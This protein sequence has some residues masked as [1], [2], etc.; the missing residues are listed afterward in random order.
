M[1]ADREVDML[2]AQA[3][4]PLSKLQAKAR[5]LLQA[6]TVR[7]YRSVFLSNGKLSADGALVLADLTRASG[8]GKVRPGASGEEL[9]F[10]E[11]RRA[12]L[13]HMFAKLDADTLERL[14][15]RIRE[16]DDDE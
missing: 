9:N 4:R 15:S 3:R 11:G 16:A 7:A 8:L 10:R 1:A 6:R 13:L 5:L 12:M 2:A 14:A